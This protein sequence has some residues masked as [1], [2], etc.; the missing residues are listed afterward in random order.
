MRKSNLIKLVL[1]VSLLVG[2]AWAAT[3]VTEVKQIKAGPA[4]IGP[5]IIEDIQML[6]DQQT[7]VMVGIANSDDARVYWYNLSADEVDG[8][9]DAGVLYG[10]RGNRG[11]AISLQGTYA[12][13]TNYPIDTV[14]V[15]DLVNSP[16][17]GEECVQT[18]TTV[19][20]KPTGVDITYP[21]SG[22][23]LVTNSFSDSITVMDPAGEV[24]SELEVGFGPNSIVASGRQWAAVVNRYDDTVHVIDIPRS[25]DVAVVEGLDRVPHTACVDPAGN[26]VYAV[27]FVGNKVDVI[28]TG[29]WSVVNKIPVGDSPRY[30]AMDTAGK[31]LYV[32][33]TID[34]TVS[35]ISTRAKA[36]VE[37]IEV[38]PP[39]EPAPIGAIAVTKDNRY[40][41]VWWTGGKSGTPADFVIFKYDVGQLFG[42]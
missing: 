12:Y 34:K 11:I 6:D 24:I 1:V 21:D 14:S 7:A 16:R 35:V 37:T 2:L 26:Y 9:C 27:D 33:N 18:E 31:F 25:E 36:V 15:I 8:Y 20:P 4:G 22:T 23:V 30:C 13:L 39:E 5:Y 40:L 17:D 42:G 38:V 28:K 3:G 19:L 41:Y 10:P 32:A 29:S